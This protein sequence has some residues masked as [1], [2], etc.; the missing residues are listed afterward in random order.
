MASMK[1]S[2]FGKKIVK[3][4][5]DGKPEF[6]ASYSTSAPTTPSQT[7]HTVSKPAV[8][9]T[10]APISAAAKTTAKKTPSKIEIEKRAY[11]IWKKKGGSAEANWLEAERELSK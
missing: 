7:T 1:D 11:E 6:T 2:G 9:N 3:A 4:G 8:S 10:A 5:S